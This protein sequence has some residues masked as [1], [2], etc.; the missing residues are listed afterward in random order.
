MKENYIRICMNNS[1]IKKLRK[2]LISIEMSY[3]LT[4]QINRDIHFKIFSLK[5][6]DKFQL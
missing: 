4:I 1:M 5:L 2:T 6:P 3:I